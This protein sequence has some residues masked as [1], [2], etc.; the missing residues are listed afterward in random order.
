[1]PNEPV[2]M[3]TS[4][5]CEPC[6]AVRDAI[7]KQ[8]GLASGAEVNFV[9]VGTEEGFKDFAQN[10]LGKGAVVPSA[11]RGDERCSISVDEDT[12][13]LI[14]SCPSDE[15]I[16]TLSITEPVAPPEPEP[17]LLPKAEIDGED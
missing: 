12:S 3:Y 4:D 5:L 13:E 16:N 7:E 1:M 8:G 17:V 14:V 11:F 15:A 2:K 6:K 10:I 9:D